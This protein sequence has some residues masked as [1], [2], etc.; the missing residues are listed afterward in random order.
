[1]FTMNRSLKRRN[2]RKR[3]PLIKRELT[4]EDISQA[5]QRNESTRPLYK[6]VFPADLLPRYTPQPESL[7][8]VNTG[9]SDTT[10]R[11][12][13][14]VYFPRK[15]CL[16]RGTSFY[17]DSL[18]SSAESEDLIASFIGKKT[19]RYR[20]QSMPVQHQQ[21][22]GCGYFVL[23]IAWLLSR[24]VEPHNLS[25]YFTKDLEANDALVAKIA[26]KEFGLT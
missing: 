19:A 12:W 20:Y 1:M 24:G 23:T 13:V 11:H 14:L 10:G 18:G 8:V 22:H 3:M 21:S 4:T 6:G 15:S 5:L 16:N 25:H 2:N 9:T 26:N 7:I 17:F